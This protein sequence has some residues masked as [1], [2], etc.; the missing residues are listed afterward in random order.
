MT[1]TPAIGESPR[2]RWLAMLLALLAHGGVL[3]ALT[4]WTVAPSAFVAPSVLSVQWL[5]EDRTARRE[6]EPDKPAKPLP[7]KPRVRPEPAPEPVHRE[8][9]AEMTPAAEVV[10]EAAPVLTASAAAPAAPAV[11]EPTP[12]VPPRFNADYLSNPAPL[13]PAVSRAAGEQGRVLLRV[14]VS[15]QGEPEQVQVGTGSGFERLDLAALEAVRHW[16]FVPARRG[17]EAV[18]A[19][20]IV[21]IQFSLRR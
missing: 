11:A 13:Y 18:T 7:M 14:L 16:K 6:P 8:P 21:P 19:W 10:E 2:L 4:R 5:G 3:A 15:P 17:L 12:I 1:I 9:P 20:V